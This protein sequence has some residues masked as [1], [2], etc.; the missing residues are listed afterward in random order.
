MHDQIQRAGADWE[1]YLQMV[2]KT[3]DEFNTDL[4]EQSRRSVKTGLV[5]DQVARQ[6]DLGVDDAEL[7]YF[8]TQQA[9]QMGVDPGL[10]ARQIA[11]GGQIGAAAAEVLRGKAIALLASKVKITDE[12]GHELDYNTLLG[13]DA[14][15]DAG[16]DASDA[17]DAE[18]RRGGGR[19][20][21][22]DRRRATAAG[23]DDAAPDHAR[24]TLGHRATPAAD[25][26]D[27]DGGGGR[28]GRGRRGR[29]RERLK[30]ARAPRPSRR[31]AGQ[32]PGGARAGARLPSVTACADSENRAA[33]AYPARAGRY[34]P[35]QR[36][37]RT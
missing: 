14:E 23:A 17:E 1:T 28:H 2:G 25:A 30:P 34:R 6:E 10:L 11:E 24:R 16:E 12:A 29:R 37:Q 5:L 4:Q 21:G 26:A 36:H 22:G 35:D 18:R 19:G 32:P 20:R 15:E 13:V 31:G 27:D 33:A 9:E 8:V 3:Q 7:S